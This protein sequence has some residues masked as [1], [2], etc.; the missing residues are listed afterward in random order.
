MIRIIDGV[1]YEGKPGD[2]FRLKAHDLG[3]GHIEVTGSKVIVWEELDWSPIAIENYLEAVQRCREE[4]VEERAQKHAE[5]AAKRARKRVR[6][7]CKSMGANTLLTLTYQA[8]EQDLDRVKRDLKEFNR[9]MLRVLPGFRFVA[10]FERQE[11][12]AYHVH[13][14]CERIPLELKA[15]NGVNVKG[16]SFNVIRAIWRGVTKDRAGNI[17]VSKG[18]KHRSAARIASYIAKYITKAF[19]DGEQWSNRWTKYGNFEV[20]P[21]LDLG[22]VRNALE[23]IRSAFDLL[24]GAHSVDTMRYSRWGDWFYLSAEKKT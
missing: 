11:R 3:N 12:G 13:M 17:D 9:R 1:A 20:P 21:V 5:Q 24:D 14:A 18:A 16:K 15:S 22:L 10:G 6:Q 8:N 2:S 7:L 4:D 23:V 19:T